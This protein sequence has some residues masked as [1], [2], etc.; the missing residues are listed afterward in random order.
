M[1]SMKLKEKKTW[2]AISI[3]S[4]FVIIA[5][6]I[7]SNHFNAKYDNLNDVEKRI[8]SEID[9]YSKENSKAK[10]WKGF[11][12]DN[13]PILAMDG[14]FGKG[15]LINP[16]N[17][18]SGIFAKKI[19]MPENSSIEVYRISSLAPQLFQF[20]FDGNFNTTGKIYKL[21]DN[22]VFYTK[23][24]DFNS[25]SKEFTSSHYITFLSHEAF[26]YYMQE[27]WAGGSRFSTESLTQKDMDLLKVEY[28]VLGKI[29]DELIEQGEVKDR[30]LQ[31]AKEY[32]EIVNKRV[33]QN[34]E[35]V[36]EELSMETAEGTATYIGIKASQIVGYDYGVMY[37]DNAK[38]V[39]LS[40][41][42]PNVEEGALDKSFLADRMPYETGALLCL[43]M[44]AI[45]VPNWQESLN[46]QTQNNPVTL[47]SILREFCEEN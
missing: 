13:S 28:E 40:E 36:E 42:M 25:I 15:F 21:F 44:D 35:Y 14:S 17:D 11:E 33:S 47:Y 34:P 41:V 12:L 4:I 38:N 19:E 8:L 31:Y 10:I 9:Q 16:I 32:V 18:V 1:Y 29:Q 23:Y 37:F 26:H 27:S 45:D 30:L 20:R 5:A 43:L 7:G 3:I 39:S 24:D 22:E 46:N 2:I 6:T